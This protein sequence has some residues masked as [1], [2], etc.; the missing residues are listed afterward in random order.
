MRLSIPY[1]R[2]PSRRSST[3]P[4]RKRASVGTTSTAYSSQSG[5]SSSS[6]YTAAKRQGRDAASFSNSCLNRRQKGHQV[7]QNMTTVGSFACTTASWNAS[8]SWPCNI[9][10]AFTTSEG[11]KASHTKIRGSAGEATQ[12]H[13]PG[14]PDTARRSRSR[15]DGMG[16]PVA[17]EEVRA[18]FAGL[19]KQAEATSAVARAARTRG[20]DPELDVDIPL[21]D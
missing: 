13:I 20:F 8:G 1:P 15:R 3:L 6:R 19:L 10:D 2:I 9:A 5:F 4:S 14:T 21:T 17:G 16:T 18:Y 12:R 7:A 11:D